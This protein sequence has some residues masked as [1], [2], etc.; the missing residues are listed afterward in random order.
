M[1]GSFEQ[2]PSERQPEDAYD[3]NGGAK[4]PLTEKTARPKSRIRDYLKAAAVALTVGFGTTAE[5][6]QSNIE[7]P[8]PEPP[9]AAQQEHGEGSAEVR[10]PKIDHLFVD[11]VESTDA[12]VRMKVEASVRGLEDLREIHFTK[13]EAE[14]TNPNLTGRSFARVYASVLSEHRFVES[15]GCVG[16]AN[17][18]TGDAH[19]REK[20]IDRAMTSALQRAVEK[21]RAES[22]VQPLEVIPKIMIDGEEITDPNMQLKFSLIFGD[23]PGV[24]VVKTTVTEGTLNDS[25]G[26]V[27]ARAYTTCIAERGI[28]EDVASDAAIAWHK[29]DDAMRAR[30]KELGVLSSWQKTAAK[31][32]GKTHGHVDQRS[33]R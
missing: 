21:F 28:K 14:G 3:E 22:L 5:A 2:R 13:Y 7:A 12:M 15:V 10:I 20:E 6:Q 29:G 16:A 25:V 32:G 1:V 26:M 9:H 19:Q 30:Q 23:V 4:T 8:K 18:K 33:L 27:L 11:G 31:F 17:W 24:R